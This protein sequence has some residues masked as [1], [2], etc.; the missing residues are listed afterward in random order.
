[1]SKYLA[2]IYHYIKE[3]RKNPKWSLF[4]CLALLLPLNQLQVEV[5]WYVLWNKMTRILAVIQTLPQCKETSNTI[6]NP[7]HS[8]LSFLKGVPTQHSQRELIGD[9]L[10][11]IKRLWWYIR[12]MIWKRVERNIVLLNFVS[13]HF[14]ILFY[15]FRTY[16]ILCLIIN[17][18]LSRHF[19][20]NRYSF[21]SVY[22]VHYSWKFR[23]LNYNQCTVL[24]Q[25][26]TF[27]SFLCA[28]RL[29]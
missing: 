27:R 10:R 22:L 28:Q 9:T 2:D 11:K 1:M 18:V 3:W 20:Q 24:V 17:S 8:I 26:T 7:I 14:E 19:C 4:C 12:D 6:V 15:F 29:I 13:E 16:G 23:S 5:K 25:V 21:Y